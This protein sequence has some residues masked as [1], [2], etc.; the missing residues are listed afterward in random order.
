MLTLQV[1][2]IY[3]SLTQQEYYIK[4]V[5]RSPSQAPEMRYFF[6]QKLTTY[7]KRSQ[8]SCRGIFLFKLRTGH[9]TVT[10]HKSK[11]NKSIR[12]LPSTFVLSLPN[13][14]VCYALWRS[15]HLYSCKQYLS[16]IQFRYILFRLA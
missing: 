14:L 11:I 5:S 7:F 2:V 9:A 8:V 6:L 15:L 13:R 16:E 4:Y 3:N 10:Q 12:L 1:M